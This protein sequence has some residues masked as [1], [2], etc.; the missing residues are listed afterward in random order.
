M[1]C[2]IKINVIDERNENSTQCFGFNV[3]HRLEITHQNN[4]VTLS[5]TPSYVSYGFGLLK[6]M[7]CFIMA[8]SLSFGTYHVH[9]GNT[10]APYVRKDI[11][12]SSF[13]T[14]FSQRCVTRLSIPFLLDRFILHD[15]QNSFAKLSGS[16]FTFKKQVNCGQVIQMLTIFFKPSVI[17]CKEYI[18]SEGNHYQHMSGSRLCF[19]AILKGYF[20]YINILFYPTVT[21]SLRVYPW[22]GCLRIVIMQPCEAIYSLSIEMVTATLFSTNFLKRY[23]KNEEFPNAYFQWG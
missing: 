6:N 14:N 7:R 19:L 23:Q 15:L 22:T 21:Q 18:L 11:S 5:S 13:H 12:S 16:T 20:K 17:K 3:S 1:I 9:D 4:L 10:N 8:T 2:C